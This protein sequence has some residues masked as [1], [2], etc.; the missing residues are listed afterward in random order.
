VTVK[1]RVVRSI[2]APGEF[3]CVDIFIWPDSEVDVHEF[4][5]QEFRRDP[6]D[7]RGW[8]PIG[9]RSSQRFLSAADALVNA[10]ERIH[11]LANEAT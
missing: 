9:G 2:N 1:N 3:R 10:K 7:N 6:E 4:G 11:W 8:Y 5:F